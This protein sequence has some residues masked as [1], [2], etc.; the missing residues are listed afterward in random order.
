MPDCIE[1]CIYSVLFFGMMSS[2]LMLKLIFE[3][4]KGDTTPV[5][6]N[7]L[8][9]KPM[10]LSSLLCGISIEKIDV[11]TIVMQMEKLIALIVSI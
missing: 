11:T 9:A 2:R 8:I 6:K 10:T 5:R 1:V 3:E 7:R 4:K